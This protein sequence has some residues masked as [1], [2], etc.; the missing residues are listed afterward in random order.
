MEGVID[1]RLAERVAG[2][3]AST[4]PAA[5]ADTAGLTAEIDGFAARSAEL[6][7]AYTGLDPGP[8][9]PV[10]ET[11][12]RGAW[13]TTNLRSV[14]TVMEPLIERAGADMGPLGVPLRA[15]AG[16]LL[17]VE[18]G[19]LSGFLATRVLGQLEFPILDPTAA[20]RLLFVGPNLAQAIRSLQADET[21]LVRWVAL[22]ETT[23]ALQFGGV[24]WLREHLATQVRSLLGATD[25][26]LDLAKISRLPSVDDLKALVESVRRDGL[27]TLLA[28]ADR[29]AALDALQATMALLEGYAEHV[30]D[31]V[32]ASELDDLDRLRAGL[33]RRRHD[34]SGLL[35]LLEKLI[36]FDLKLRQYE[37]GKAFCDAVVAEGGIA[38][39]N[40]A[41]DGPAALPT[42]DE[43]DRPSDWLA[44]V[45]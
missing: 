23:H 37:Q 27:I 40:R 10:P 2:L 21:T 12:D 7:G 22:H 17:A 5:D 20:A 16:T 34:R 29:K 30:M 15:V 4:T 26:K 38:G 25:L 13:A 41:W 33:E 36:G 32:G 1:W 8:A 24:P 11:I 35:Q 39:L 3:V 43:L 6:V 14:R 42:L 45:A 31:A 9:L 28:G 44:R 18:A 19:A